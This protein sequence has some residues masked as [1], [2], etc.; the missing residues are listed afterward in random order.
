MNQNN[1]RIVEQHFCTN[2]PEKH[3][4]F[5]FIERME[6]HAHK[7]IKTLKNIYLNL[8]ETY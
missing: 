1:L 6:K 8:I 5:T 3:K 2:G 4:I 7:L